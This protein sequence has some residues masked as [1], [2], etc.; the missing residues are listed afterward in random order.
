MSVSGLTIARSQKAPTTP[1]FSSVPTGLLQRKCACGQHTGAGGE[2]ESCRK[3][4][5]GT[6]QRTAVSPSPVNDVLPIVHEVLRSPGQPLDSATR[7]FMEPRF[8]YDLSSI[9]VSG[10]GPPSMQSQLAI[11]QPEDPSEQQ[12]DALADQVTCMSLPRRERRYDFSGVRIHTDAGAAESARAVNAL[13]YTVGNHVVFGVGQ[14][15]PT[16]IGGKHLLAHELAHTIQQGR[17]AP[18]VQRVCDPALLAGRTNPI[19]FPL[20]PTIVDVFRGVR[21][22]T[23]SVTPNTAVGLVQQALVDLGFTLGTGG[24]NGDGVDRKFGSATTTAITAFQTAE[25]IAGAA[26]GILDEPTLK[27]LDDKRSQLAVPPHQAGT[28]TPAQVQISGEAAGGRDED[29]FF[30][31]GSSTLDANDKAKIGRLLTRAAN[32]LKGCPITLEGFVSE[33]ELAEFGSGLATDRIN[34]VD[35]E[36]VGQKHDDPGPACPAPALPL[37]TPSPLPAVSSGVS[38][39]RSRRKVE[40]VPVGATSTTAP[41]PP[42]SPQNR[43]LTGPENTT[44]TDAIDQAVAWMNA[45]IGELTPGDPEGNAALTA[46]FGGTGRRSTIKANL[47]TWRDHLDSVARV[48]NRHGTQCNAT[49]R[50]AIAFNQGTGAGAQMTVC[51]PFF[52]A[53]TTHPALNQDEKK[54]FVMMHEAGHGAIATRDTA[55]GHRRLIEF[56][57]GFPAIAE[58]NT[59][60]YTLM[61]LCLNGFAGFCAAPTTTDTTAGMSGPEEIKSRRG[62]AWLQTWLT[63]AQQDTSSMY[64]RMNVARESGQGLRSISTYYADVY[65]VLVAAFNVHRP[66]GD[67]PPTMQEQTM[68]AAVLDRVLL[69]ERATAAGLTVEKD[70]SAMPTARWDAGPGRHVFLTDAYFLLL[71][72]RRRVEFLLPLIIR[73]NTAISS[74]LEPVY[75]TY[76]KNNVI[77][78]RGNRPTP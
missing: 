43:A 57:A 62:L 32:P 41:C 70:T 65:G 37:R 36:F 78:S 8:G 66:P 61:V 31:R 71:S 77:V 19:F 26:P 21:T 42:G 69:M 60:S 35:A 5:E 24:P 22:L 63:W 14:Y 44:L 33:D 75:E 15:V 48:N 50:T 23:P 1:T 58:T 46:Y 30:D 4:R 11:S 18:I 12:A 20:E 52:Q 72:D 2:C 40:V 29:I 45:A 47:I 34:A 73:A 7:A 6:L 51:P 76:I 67:P 64:G 59:D 17:S 27:C 56:L 49:C 10:L 16:T 74:A 55:Y 28:V 9:Q 25:T 53:M 3:K 38:D 39:Y 68:V 54:A 13:A